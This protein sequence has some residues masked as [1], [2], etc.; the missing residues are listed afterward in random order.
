MKLCLPIVILL[1][2][3][4]AACSDRLTTSTDMVFDNNTPPPDSTTFPPDSTTF[5][6]IQENVFNLSCALS[7]CHK[8]LEFPNLSAGHAYANI[9]NVP[10]S[11]EFKLIA[12]GNPDSS[13]LYIKITTGSGLNRMPRGRPPLLASTIEAVR[14]WIERGAP[15]D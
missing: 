5:S 4:A 13:Y 6:F 10:S 8:D 14:K 9:V 3:L 15:N 7:G 1:A 12:P 2:L 11:T